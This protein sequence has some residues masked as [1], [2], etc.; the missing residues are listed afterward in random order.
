VITP[1]RQRRDT[2]TEETTAAPE[3][4]PGCTHADPQHRSH[5]YLSLAKFEGPDALRAHVKKQFVTV[6]DQEKRRPDVVEDIMTWIA[7]TMELYGGL[8]HPDTGAQ[9]TWA[10]ARAY[11]VRQQ[12]QIAQ[13]AFERAPAGYRWKP[14][15]LEPWLRD[16]ML[17]HAP[18][19]TREPGEDRLEDI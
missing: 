4:C 3:V 17:K 7:D 1:P 19:V 2:D 16:V 11:C 18:V 12:D 10:E 13:R 8:A 6:R 5:H 15:N 14:G 9:L